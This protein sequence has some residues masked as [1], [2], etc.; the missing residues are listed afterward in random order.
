MP[1][2]PQ[3]RPRTSPNYWATALLVMVILHLRGGNT[4]IVGTSGEIW[5]MLPHHQQQGGAA[6]QPP[7]PRRCPP[8]SGRH[9]RRRP[10]QAPAA[11]LKLPHRCC[12]QPGH[13]QHSLLFAHPCAGPSLGSQAAP[14]PR[15]Q[16]HQQPSYQVRKPAGSRG[17]QTAVAVARDSSTFKGGADRPQ[18]EVHCVYCCPPKQRLSAS[19][20]PPD[21]AVSPGKGRLEIHS[22]LG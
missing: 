4:T 20:A 3:R 15:L 22:G 16:P 17:A 6:H 5:G 21:C 11:H 10:G 18:T 19:P 13:R 8:Q 7:P 14:S 2:C 9:S 12:N 1:P